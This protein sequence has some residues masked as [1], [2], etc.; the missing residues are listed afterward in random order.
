MI[1]TQRSALHRKQLFKRAKDPA[2]PMM[3]NAPAGNDVCFQCIVAEWGGGVGS[4]T[5][6]QI[7][8]MDY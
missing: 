4:I 5:V 2:T 7:V 1:I 8:S 6:V 3:A